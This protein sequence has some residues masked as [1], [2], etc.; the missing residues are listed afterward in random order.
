MVAISASVSETS[1]L[2]CWTP[3][4]FS[5]NQGGISR[6]A[7]FS[8]IARA[9]GRASSYV[10]NDIGARAP[11]RWQAWQERCRIGAT[12]RVNVTSAAASAAPAATAEALPSSRA[13]PAAIR[14]ACLS[15]DCIVNGLLSGQPTP[16]DGWSPCASTQL[17]LRRIARMVRDAFAQCQ[18]AGGRRAARARRRGTG[19]DQ[20]TVTVTSAF[21]ISPPSWAITRSTYVPGAANVAVTGNL[22]SAGT[23]GGAQPGDQGELPR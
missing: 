14:Q 4:F 3:M 23:G 12:S 9:Q 6:S 15:V 8:F 20:C 19:P 10:T 17:W 1:S 5:M 21:V 11:G 16:R 18:S 13:N 22:P 2:K 7:V